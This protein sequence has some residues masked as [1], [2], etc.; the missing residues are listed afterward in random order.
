[1]TSLDKVSNGLLDKQT[2][3]KAF[4]ELGYLIRKRTNGNAYCELIV[5]GGASILLNYGF[6]L[7]TSDIDCSD[8]YKVLMND[9]ISFVASKYN[10]PE[11]W[12]NSNFTNT[13]S[14]SVNLKRVS[15]HYKSYGNGVLEIRTIK[16]LY[17]LAMKI[18]SGRKY[19]NDYSDILGIISIMTEKKMM[20]NKELL[21]KAIIELYGTHDVIDIDAYD[22]ALEVIKNPNKYHYSEIVD[23]EKTN[24]KTI[25]MSVHTN[26]NQEELEYVLSKLDL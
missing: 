23:I 7:T 22:F 8:E 5:V 21:D 18:V 2:I 11:Y 26:M 24:L 13:K 3:E 19:K 10:L 25:K 9:L 12:I 20:I 14:Y 6:R 1:M 15:S 16:D 4:K 17:L